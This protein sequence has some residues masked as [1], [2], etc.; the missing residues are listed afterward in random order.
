MHCVINHRDIIK[1]YWQ[2]WY[3]SFFC[4]LC[5]VSVHVVRSLNLVK[6]NF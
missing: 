3:A 4:A 1:I 6:Y 5:D 2:F